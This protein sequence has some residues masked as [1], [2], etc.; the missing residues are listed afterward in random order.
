[1]SSRL[2]IDGNSVYEIDEDCERSRLAGGREM[3]ERKRLKTQGK[4]EGS[5]KP[6]GKE[7]NG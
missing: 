5:E 3:S 1:M 2:I 4:A 6:E 7:Q